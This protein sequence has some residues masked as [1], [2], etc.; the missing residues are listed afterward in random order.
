VRG[1]LPA[2]PRSLGGSISWLE[3]CQGDVLAATSWTYVTGRDGESNTGRTWRLPEA[4]WTNNR[5][6]AESRS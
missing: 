2:E 1:Q 4:R 3:P 6:C 5:S